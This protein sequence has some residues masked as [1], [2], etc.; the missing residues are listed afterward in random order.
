[1]KKENE[2]IS[3]FLGLEDNQEGWDI[4]GNPVFIMEAMEKMTSLTV[5]KF[6][7]TWPRFAFTFRGHM[8]VVYEENYYGERI[9]RS[10]SNEGTLLNNLYNCIV[11]CIKRLDK[12]IEEE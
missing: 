3:G 5:T 1:M 12:D 11:E 9:W 6:K 10:S 7:S 4:Q 2:L 8:V